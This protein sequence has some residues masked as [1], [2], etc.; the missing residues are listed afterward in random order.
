M[1][2]RG[3]QKRSVTE[4]ELRF[5]E[6]VKRIMFPLSLGDLGQIKKD[7]PIL[8]GMIKGDREAIPLGN[9][10]LVQISSEAKLL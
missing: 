1:D 9:D 3:D 5:L 6:K 8:R 10:S 7:I 4:R 2:C